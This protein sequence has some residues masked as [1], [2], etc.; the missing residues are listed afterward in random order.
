MKRIV[1]DLIH[2]E[3]NGILLP[4]GFRANVRFCQYRTD[5]LEKHEIMGMK[6]NFSRSKYFSSQSY[7][8]SDDRVKATKLSDVLPSNFEK[9]TEDTYKVGCKQRIIIFIKVLLFSPS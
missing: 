8:T 5:N 2:L 9:R 4:N 1:A 3:E 6:K 7:I